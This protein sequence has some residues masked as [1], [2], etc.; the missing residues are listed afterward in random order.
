MNRTIPGKLDMHALATLRGD[1]A[2]RHKPTHADGLRH[3]AH[4]LAGQGLSVR[5]I[6]AAL[7]VP[8]AFVTGLL[9]EPLTE[10]DSSCEP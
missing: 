1:P 10:G 3:A 9:A 7:R 4:A 2:T 5:D 6:A 8:P